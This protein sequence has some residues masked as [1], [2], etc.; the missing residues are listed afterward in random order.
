MRKQII[1]F[2]NRTVKVEVKVKFNL[3]QAMKAQRESRR[4][5]LTPRFERNLQVRFILIFVFQ[6]ASS[7]EINANM[8]CILK[9]QFIPKRKPGNIKQLHSSVLLHFTHKQPFVILF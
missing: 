1:G 9:I 6:R 4:V 8:D 3:E 2:Y 7:F 5:A